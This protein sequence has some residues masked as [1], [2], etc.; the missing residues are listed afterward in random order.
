ME[1]SLP[2]GADALNA[3]APT[4]SEF[5]KNNIGRFRWGKQKNT[6]RSEACF[7]NLTP[8]LSLARRGGKLFYNYFINNAIFN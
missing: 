2:T 4:Q 1:Y 3:T 8:T 6:L 5:I 7:F